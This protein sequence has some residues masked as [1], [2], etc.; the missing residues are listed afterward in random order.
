VTPAPCW[1]FWFA[2]IAAVASHQPWQAMLAAVTSW[3]YTEC[4]FR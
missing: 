4:L 2:R 1:V 3:C